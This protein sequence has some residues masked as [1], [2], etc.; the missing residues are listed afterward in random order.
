MVPRAPL[1]RWK[2]IFEI[3]S[4]KMSFDDEMGVEDALKIQDQKDVVAESPK[5]EDNVTFLQ[6][7]DGTNQNDNDLLITIAAIVMILIL[8][9]PGMGIF[10]YMIFHVTWSDQ[11]IYIN[12]A[13]SSLT[14]LI[15]ISSV[16]WMALI[17]ASYLSLLAVWK[18]W[19]RR[20]RQDIEPQ[21][22]SL[23]NRHHVQ[24]RTSSDS[25]LSPEVVDL[26]PLDGSLVSTTSLQGKN[27][28]E[29]T[30]SRWRQILWRIMDGVMESTFLVIILPYVE[31]P[32]LAADALGFLNLGGLGTLA[33][34]SPEWFLATA[35][36]LGGI[37]V[38]PM[39]I[40]MIFSKQR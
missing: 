25:E 24:Y 26:F 15:L 3:K 19:Q 6:G 27:G 37:N 10:A 12:D 8:V 28:T 1:G 32:L 31:A 30:S 38:I 9:V 2:G 11:T 33:F 34:S 23:E 36:L 29:M 5:R 39:L 18:W 35:F 13:M 21:R 17:M 40:H 20:S 22:V 4:L 7:T 16:E 14:V